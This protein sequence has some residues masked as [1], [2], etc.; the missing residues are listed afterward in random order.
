MS[1][2]L[3]AL[4]MFACVPPQDAAA[5]PLLDTEWQLS[6]AIGDRPPHVRFLSE[7]NRVEGSGGCNTFSGTYELNGSQLRITGPLMMTMRACAQRDLSTQE[8]RFISTLTEV[9]SYTLTGRSLTLT[10]PSSSLKLEVGKLVSGLEKQLSSST[11]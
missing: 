2:L 11:L 1:R 10:T 5:T 7:G 8:S 4:M 9:T 3:L 6:D